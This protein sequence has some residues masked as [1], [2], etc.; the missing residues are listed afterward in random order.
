MSVSNAERKTT[1]N[2]TGRR[3]SF[4]P[5]KP[6]RDLL[7]DNHYWANTKSPY[8]SLRLPF[9]SF[10]ELKWEDEPIEVEHTIK[11]I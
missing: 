2:P 8:E 4:F 1:D 7:T 10:P 9:D 6:V 5:N 11:Q 3:V